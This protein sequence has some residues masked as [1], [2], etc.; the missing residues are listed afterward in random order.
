M[1]NEDRTPLNEEQRKLY[2]KLEEVFMP[3]ARVQRNKF[4]KSGTKSIARFV[5]YT[6]AEAALKIITSK[7]FWM[8]NTNCMADYREVRHG[9]ELFSNLFADQ[10]IV[11]RFKNTLDSCMEG[12]SDEAFNLFNSWWQSINVGTF[13]AS[14][15]EHDDS[16]DSHGRL[17]MWRAFGGTTARVA[18]V[19]NIP[20]V[21]PGADLLDIR[22]SPVAY[23]NKTET[24]QMFNQIIV[25][26][27]QNREFLKTVQRK[28]IL[29]IIFNMLL[30]GVTCFKHEGFR[31]EREWRIV[32][33]PAINHSRLIEFSTEI[34]AGVP[35]HVYKLPLDASVHPIL[36]DI[37]LSKIFDRLIIGPSPY[38]IAMHQA[39]SVALSKAG[40]ELA[41]TKVF[42]SDIP[43]RS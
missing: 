5:H 31:E 7:R 2:I 42:T 22:F 11:T 36:A 4:Y 40:V 28:D 23:L 20:W 15:S 14:I 35:Q 6:S 18:I 10:D 39:F 1:P 9:F 33:C 3:H 16:E 29:N 21:S 26:I 17:S 41:D 24:R 25:N 30:L 32:H 8:R 27:Q 19:F 38:P 43:I 13:I 12:I 37:E 34:V